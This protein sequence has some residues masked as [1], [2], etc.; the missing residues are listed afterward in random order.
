MSRGISRSIRCISAAAGL[1]S[2][3]CWS[4]L[5][6]CFFAFLWGVCPFDVMPLRRALLRFGGGGG[7]FAALDAQRPA[8]GLDKAGEAAIGVIGREAAHLTQALGALGQE[9]RQRESGEAGTA[10]EARMNGDADLE[11][12]VVEGDGGHQ[13]VCHWQTEASVLAG[14]RK[15]EPNDSVQVFRQPEAAA[16]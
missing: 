4:F 7:R 12:V 3:V 2:G 10:E 14:H 11:A 15:R 8:V 13:S 9:R 16:R 5:V 1:L 6:Y